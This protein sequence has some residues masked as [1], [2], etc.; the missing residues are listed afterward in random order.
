MATKIQIKRDTAANWAATNPVL[1]AGE[2]G[3]EID[4]GIVKY[5]N[6]TDAWNSLVVA[7]S[8]EN[9]FSMKAWSGNDWKFI[10][11]AGGKSFKFKTAG[12]VRTDIRLTPTLV[13]EIYN[14]GTMTLSVAEHPTLIDSVKTAW[15]N[16]DNANGGRPYYFR[17]ND[18][19]H[20][21]YSYT[22]TGDTMVVNLH[23]ETG[24]S[25]NTGDLIQF[26]GWSKGTQALFDTYTS[27]VGVYDENLAY[28]GNYWQPTET[29]ANTNTITLDMSGA[30]MGET[31]K[32]INGSGK[33][34]IVFD[35]YTN[36]NGRRITSASLVS[37]NIYNITFA[38]APINVKAKTS[39][40]LVC[41]PASETDNSYWLHLSK[42]EYPQLIDFLNIDNGSVYFTI[43]D[44]DTQYAVSYFW[45]RGGNDSTGDGVDYHNRWTLA[46]DDQF[47]CV[48][49]DT[50]TL[51][52]VEK[53]TFIR[54]DYW[55]PEATKFGNDFGTS[56]DRGYRWFS[57]ENDL[58]HVKDAKG[59]GV[60]GGWID[61][62]VQATWPDG[63]SRNSD[64]RTFSIF[65]D[66]RGGDYD[67]NDFANGL[68]NFRYEGYPVQSPFGT[69]EGPNQPYNG[70]RFGGQWY[71]LQFST[72]DEFYEDG[73]FFNANSYDYDNG[74]Q[75]E[76]KIDILWNARI[77][78]ADTPMLEPNDR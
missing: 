24:V 75:Q 30:E 48:A 31:A 21:I 15:D 62:H 26:A 78:Y 49:T 66:T 3:M 50:I 42:Q 25:Y 6:G 72:T 16:W 56:S 12:H 54:F 39:K 59:N 27:T 32:L 64:N 74:N 18:L 58:P 45:P 68:N 43:N 29:L 46:C 61:Y 76:V 53:G 38:G 44:D 52:Y 14:N 37:G 9:N 65:F 67:T 36:N 19:Q 69:G 20:W 1:S 8:T 4:T 40:T 5:G 70:G 34:Y 11:S 57:W 77:F 28:T 10:S 33:N 63:M 7:A 2:P 23:D 60:Q 71:N 73:I 47:S 13:S 22:L 17:N 55:V 51:H 35:P 41:K